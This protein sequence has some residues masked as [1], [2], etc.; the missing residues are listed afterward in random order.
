MIC[1]VLESKMRELFNEKVFPRVKT[2]ELSA[3]VRRSGH[4]SPPKADEPFCTR[5]QEI[6]YLD[7]NNRE[8]ARA[9]R[10]LRPDGTIGAS[11]KPDPKRVFLDGV[12][13]RL[14]KKRHR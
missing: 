10:Y 14:V 3:L 8:V 12:M 7:Q 5:S 9:H 2:G 6:S 11:G 1:R 4:P 13:Y